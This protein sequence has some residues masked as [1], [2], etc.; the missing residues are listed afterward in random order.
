[1]LL[2]PSLLF[3]S[4]TTPFTLKGTFLPSHLSLSLL[5][6]PSTL[7]M[8]THKNPNSSLPT[9]NTSHHSVSGNLIPTSR[10][11]RYIAAVARLGGW[12]VK[13]NICGLNSAVF[14]CPIARFARS[15]ARGWENTS[16]AWR[17]V[18]QSVYGRLAETLNPNIRSIRCSTVNKLARRRS[19][20]PSET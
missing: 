3:I 17:Y 4:S 13:Y 12:C 9:S 16:R 5:A 15:V 10:A 2:S 1:M 8:P 20:V 19:Y 18:M 11:A 6:N 14:K 7:N